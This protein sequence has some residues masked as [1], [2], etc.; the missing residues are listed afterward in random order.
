MRQEKF[1]IPSSTR[2]VSVPVILD[3]SNKLFHLHF[4]T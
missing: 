2:V 1:V 3:V 4:G